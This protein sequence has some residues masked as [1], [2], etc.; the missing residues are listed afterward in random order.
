MSTFK[1]Y[2]YIFNTLEKAVAD[3]R[4][5]SKQMPEVY[6][7]LAEDG[8]LQDYEYEAIAKLAW[9]ATTQ[10]IEA[11]RT[12]TALWDLIRAIDRGA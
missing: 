9:R 12:I 1:D 3:V 10:T 11:K 6:K 8:G 5:L 7:A 4:F 2:E